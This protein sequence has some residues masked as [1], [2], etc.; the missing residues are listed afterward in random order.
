MPS[1]DFSTSTWRSAYAATCGQVGDHQHL[2]AA[3]PA[4]PA[5]GRPRPPRRRP[6]PASTS[7][8]TNVGTGLVAGQG[9]LEGQH[10]AGELAARGALVQRPRLGAGVGGQQQLDLVDAVGAGAQVRPHRRGGPPGRRT[11]PALP[12][13]DRQPGVGH[14]QLGE[15][16]GHLPP[17]R[18]AAVVAGRARARRRASAS[19]DAQRVALGRAARRSARRCRRGRAAGRGRGSAQ[20]STS[21][22]VSPYLRVSAVS[23]ARRSET[24]ARRAGSVSIRLA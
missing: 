15:L 3:R 13:G 20:A 9:D 21:S 1:L 5:G 19:C 2:R 11:R 14:R 17:S 24:A 16:R 4:G 18:S 7:S 8:K 10:H 22:M 23:A 12:H 6:T